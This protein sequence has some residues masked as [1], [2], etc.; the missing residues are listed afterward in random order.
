MTIT[1][2]LAAAFNTLILPFAS[3]PILVTGQVNN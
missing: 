3:P 1:A 2:A